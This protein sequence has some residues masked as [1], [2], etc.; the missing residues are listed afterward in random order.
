MVITKL[1]DLQK[2]LFRKEITFSFYLQKIASQFLFRVRECVVDIRDMVFRTRVSR[3]IARR[4]FPLNSLVIRKQ[5]PADDAQITELLSGGWIGK[6]VRRIAMKKITGDAADSAPEQAPEIL[7]T[8][9][10]P[11][12]ECNFVV[13]H[14][15]K[16]IGKIG[17][18]KSWK[19]DCGIDAYV[20]SGT[21]VKRWYRGLGIGEAMHNALLQHARDL[22]EE[23]VYQKIVCT[24][25][26]NMRL[27]AKLGFKRAGKEI[28][29]RVC[30]TSSL[31]ENRSFVFRL[32]LQ[33]KR[34]VLRNT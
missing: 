7:D 34:K 10:L 20:I 14:K 33:K 16:I 22:N 18:C 25:E 29:N 8:G 13:E 24:N 19:R 3:N 26:R 1:L 9:M 6:Y 12:N 28:E 15:G 5:E 30:G 11:E 32:D 27:A 4:F 21:Y 31:H 17:M 2:Q 23:T